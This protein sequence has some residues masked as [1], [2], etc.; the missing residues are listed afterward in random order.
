MMKGSENHGEIFF[1][2]IMKIDRNYFLSKLKKIQIDWRDLN[3]EIF[4]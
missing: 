3:V 1:W 4:R 2:K